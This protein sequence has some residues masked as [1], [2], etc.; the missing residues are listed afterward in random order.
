MQ[1]IDPTTPNARPQVVAGIS[2]VAL[3]TIL[4]E[5]LLTRIFS[6]TMW[7]HF[8]FMAVS[9]AM[10]GMTVGAIIVFLRPQRFPNASLLSTMGRYAL[11]LAWAFPLS[12]L[13][14]V[15]A[16]FAD[17]TGS[18]LALAYTFSITAL[19]F[20][21]SGIVVCCTGIAVRPTVRRAGLIGILRRP[22]SMKTIAAM[23]SNIA[24]SSRIMPSAV[25]VPPVVARS[26]ICCAALVSGTVFVAVSAQ[27]PPSATTTRVDA[28]FDGIVSPGTAMETVKSGFG[29][30]NGI[31]WVRGPGGGHLLISDIPANVVHRWTP[32]GKM[33]PFLEK[34]DWTR[35][36]GRPA[37]PRFGANGITID[38]QGRVVYAAEADRAIV[39]MEKDGKRTILAER[40]EGKRLNSPNDLVFRSDGALYFT[41]PSGGNRFADW[42]LKKELPYQGV[43]LLK[44]GKLQ[45]GR[46]QVAGGRT[47]G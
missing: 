2:L 39:R 12:V 46:W 20:I 36:P 10:F 3:A 35:T 26:M 9:I 6:L 1:T 32:D 25:C 19:P 45:V 31:V 38:P 16:P 23:I 18:A 14:H 13:A 4:F 30:I 8:A 5:V 41:D 44:D 28:A 24:A 47:A 37:N 11:A 43:F 17:R 42:D 27:T 34:P 21:F 29:F 22:R 15:Y 33:S 40:Y 7:Y